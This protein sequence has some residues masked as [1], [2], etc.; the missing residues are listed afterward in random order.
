MQITYEPPNDEVAVEIA[1]LRERGN[2]VIYDWHN[3]FAPWVRAVHYLEMTGEWKALRRH[4]SIN[5]MEQ[6]TEYGPA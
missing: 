6:F 1:R 5:Q 4:R 2:A 3:A